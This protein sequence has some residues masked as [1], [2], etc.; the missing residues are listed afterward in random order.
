MGS[1]INSFSGINVSS[2]S[3]DGKYLFF[4]SNESKYKSYSEKPLTYEEKIKILSGPGS[5]SLDIYWMDARIIEQLRSEEYK[6]K[7]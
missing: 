4:F 6:N 5:G 1:V 2:V 7:K 3:P